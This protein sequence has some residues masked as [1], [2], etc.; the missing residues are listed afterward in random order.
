MAEF[1]I[2]LFFIAGAFFFMGALRLIIEAFGVS[3]LWG[4]VCLVFPPAAVLFVW[5]HWE[6]TR[7]P[8]YLIVLAT[9]L[10]AITGA[11]IPPTPRPIRP[12]V[13]QST[14]QVGMWVPPPLA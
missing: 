11:V 6:D 14:D 5:F 1:A 7:G 2:I 12:P 3:P 13:S 4:L 10:A 8:F 9:L